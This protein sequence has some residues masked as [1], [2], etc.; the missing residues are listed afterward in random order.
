ML[1]VSCGKFVHGQTVFNPKDIRIKWA[2]VANHYHDKPNFLATITVHNATGHMIPANGWK[3]YF[4]LRYHTTGLVS[5]NKD[6]E[7]QHSSGDLFYL[8]PTGSFTGIDNGGKLIIPFT[9]G[10]VIA[11]YQDAPSGFFWVNDNDD[12]PYNIPAANI[13]HDPGSLKGTD[14]Q[15]IFDL[16]KGTRDLPDNQLP[17]FIPQPVV[18]TKSKGSFKLDES[19]SIINEGGFADEASYLT[20]EIRAITGRILV[21]VHGKKN[22][23]LKKNMLPKEAYELKITKDSIVISASDGAGIFYGIQSIKNM[24]PIDA[25]SAKRAS[26]NINCAIVH[27]EPR[28]PIRAFMLD[29]SRNFQSKAEILKLLDVMALYK[30]NTF[31][32]HLTDD[33]GWRIQ[34]PGLPELT[35]IGS[36]R[37]Y[38]YIYNERLQPSYGSGASITNKAGSGFYSRKDFIEILKYAKT[39]HIDVIPEIESPGHARAAVIAMEARYRKYR[40]AGDLKKATEYLL[41]DLQDS[42]KYSSAQYFNDNVMNPALPSTYRFVTKVVDELRAMYKAAGANL[43]RIHMGGDEVPNGAWEG[44]G[45][46]KAMMKKNTAI[47]DVNDVFQFYFQQIQQMLN[48]R[49]LKLYAWEELTIGTQKNDSSR[50]VVPIGEFLKNG[51]SVDAWYN[52][53]GNEDIPYQVANAGYKTILTCID[54][55]YFDLAYQRSFYEPGD[56]WLGF[57]ETKKTLSFIPYDYYRNAKSDLQGNSYAKG[58]FNNK[59]KLTAEGRKNI[60]GIQGAL[61]GENIMSAKQMEYMILPRLL[62]LAEKAWSKQPQWETEQDTA[63][64]SVQYEQYWNAFANQLG[65]KEL[66]KLTWYHNGY[67]FRIPAPG[68]LHSGGL[69]TVNQQLPGMTIRY[70]TD[71]SE[72]VS[73]SAVYNGPTKLTGYVKMRVFDTKGRGGETSSIKVE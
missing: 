12:I 52:V 47:H 40:K 34:I 61:W 10:G 25:W 17:A 15:Y 49:G 23:I 3:F 62:A 51:V 69:V 41:S 16:N 37:G 21:S 42:S 38:P 45:V 65:K 27:D 31:H 60:I 55:F 58:Y 48:K 72:P 54:Y 39:R 11:N 19:V 26:L 30:L 32:F 43:N 59:Q 73:T 44:S 4:S 70:T 29:V 24:L 33:E 2:F 13:T 8:K 1:F 6:V 18:Y 67:N 20:K 66:P 35:T 71:G 7:I 36:N 63:K 14:A 28:F 64:L 22:I 56:E 50:N 9:G 46:I 68:I 53:E 5:E 57:L